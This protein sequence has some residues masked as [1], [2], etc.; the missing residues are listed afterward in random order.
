MSNPRDHHFD[1]SLN[2]TAEKLATLAEASRRWTNIFGRDLSSTL[3][4]FLQTTNKLL[5]AEASALFVVPEDDP[6]HL[7][8]MASWPAHRPE[9]RLLRIITEKGKGLTGAMAALGEARKLHGSELTNHHYVKR[10][11]HST[12]FLPSGYCYSALFL[13]VKDRK[14]RLKGM[15]KANNKQKEGKASEDNQFTDEDMALGQ[16]LANTAG[17][18][19]E[20][21][22]TF[23]TLSTLMSD[24]HKAN[25]PLFMLHRILEKSCFLLNADRGDLILWDDT[26]RDLVVG[27]QYDKKVDKSADGKSK[28]TPSPLPILLTPSICRKVWETRDHCLIQDVHDRQW[29]VHYHESDRR[30]QS[31]VT[32]LLKW[33]GA[34]IG[35][36][37][38]ESFHINGFDEQDVQILE[39]LAQFAAIAYHVV[40]TQKHFRDIVQLASYMPPN[41]P[42]VAREFLIGM[43]TYLSAIHGGDGGIIYLAD[44]S[45]K[46]LVCEAYISKEH[47]NLENPRDFWYRFDEEAFS[48]RVFNDK[49]SQFANDPWNEGL[50]SQKGL[51]L[52]H[53]KGPL[54][55]VPLLY[56]ENVVGVLVLWSNRQG[57][58]R[59]EYKTRLKPFADLVATSI[60]LSQEQQ[61]EA[62]A[63]DCILPLTQPEDRPDE[64]LHH[65]LHG[66]YILGFERVCLFDYVHGKN[67]VGRYSIGMEELEQ[68]SGCIIS[69]DTNRYAAHTIAKA[70]TDTSSIVF[71]PTNPQWFGPDPDGHKIGKD[72]RQPWAV[73]PLVFEGKVYGQIIAFNPRSWRTISSRALSYL[74]LIG[75]VTAYVLG[76]SQTVE[77]LSWKHLPALYRRVGVEEP[78]ETIIRRLLVYLTCGEALRF[79]R[80]LFLEFDP[81]RNQWVY[82][83]RN[84]LGSLTQER[85]DMIALMAKDEGIDA[86][87]DRASELDDTEFDQAMK[88]FTVSASDPEF[89]QLLLHVE[90]RE[91]SRTG[92][93]PEWAKELEQRIDTNQFFGV[94]VSDTTGA[95]QTAIHG[96][97]L[98]DRR[99]HSRDMEIAQ[100]TVLGTFAQ[101]ASQI[102]DKHVMVEQMLRKE[103]ETWQQISFS[104]A[105]KLGNPL[106]SIE[107]NL[108]TLE[109]ILEEKELSEALELARCI[110]SSM[111]KA[112]S[113]IHQFKALTRAEQIKQM[114]VPLFPLI[115]DVCAVALQQNI[116]CQFDVDP[117]ITLDADEQRL[118]ECLTELVHNAIYWL[119]RSPK[120]IH[121]S[122][123][124]ADPD[125]L[126]ETLNRTR[127]YAQIR[128]VDSGEG[129][130][131]ANKARIFDPFFS[132][133]VGGTGLGLAM[134]RRIIDRHGGFIHECGNYHQGAMFELFMPLT[135]T[136][137]LPTNLSSTEELQP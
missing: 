3:E 37:N 65:L 137:F 24:M 75:A 101:I 49:M 117:T 26:R 80:A 70:K 122:A 99:F 90:P 32:V 82:K 135:E 105:H 76:K 12:D 60:G 71:D 114:P 83:P 86:I 13:P 28:P 58:F 51:A 62:F 61:A 53:I 18:V 56:R 85:F 98:V 2:I 123:E 104:A 111:E 48:T 126:P 14:G 54:I 20:N 67:F 42:Q 89:E 87:L 107:T 52:F 116:E 100:K 11:P 4:D 59:E 92:M 119:K 40:G 25:T 63:I 41:Y 120:W 118:Q 133:R 102:F 129:V 31:E 57:G 108:D 47:V 33:E 9:E 113:V 16:I 72:P 43:L 68:F 35:V 39:L 84:G 73:A 23:Q 69:R 81:E 6:E 91:F 21:F 79:N 38:C 134:V 36:L 15:L 27:C 77:L 115:E 127:R 88:D 93:W 64:T 131:E 132:T 19:L 10:D 125:Q 124:L 121:I 44:H 94:A 74:N 45:H 8:L 17:L 112:K 34:R 22:H 130:P 29:R 95:G 128:I 1:S 136:S 103:A 110:K 55:G 50:A 7:E 97:F 66:L 30:T 109:Q 5:E 78:R 46:K 106:F 96:V